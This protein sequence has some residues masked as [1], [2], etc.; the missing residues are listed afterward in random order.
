MFE[1]QQLTSAKE[2]GDQGTGLPVTEKG[3]QPQPVVPPIVPPAQEEKKVEDILG[4]IDKDV[5]TPPPVS[6]MPGAGGMPPTTGA[7]AG[8]SNK[9][10]LIIIIHF[11]L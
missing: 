3:S 10:I 9:M 2:L 4:H 5:P 1:D 11:I 7:L 6:V 8:G